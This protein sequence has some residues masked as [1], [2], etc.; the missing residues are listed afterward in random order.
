MYTFFP[1]GKKK[2]CNPPPPPF[3]QIVLE[4]NHWKTSYHV[5]T[6]KNLDGQSFFFGRYLFVSQMFEWNS[7][8]A[9]AL[10]L[11]LLPTAGLQQASVA[12]EHNA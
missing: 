2:N 4:N 7:V 12:K 11:M 6:L 1:I 3:V 10:I 5:Y 9:S 8:F